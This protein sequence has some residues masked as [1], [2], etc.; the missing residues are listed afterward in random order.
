MVSNLYP[1]VVRG[2]YE[3]ECAGV[4]ERL[5]GAGH[6]VRVLTSSEERAVHPASEDVVR[7]LDFLD[8]VR[9]DSLR[10][11]V[12]A[13]RGARTMRRELASFRPE[14]VF[15]WNGSQVPHA[16][17]RI[18]ATSGVPLAFRI[19]EHWFGTLYSSDT[20]MRHLVPGERGLRGIWARLM[21]L[22]N[23]HPDLRL[24]LEGTTP[25]AL[26]WNSHALQRLNPVPPT[27]APVLEDLVYP[28]TAQAERFLAVTRAPEP[29]PTLAYV[30]RVARGKGPDVAY[31]AL[32]ALRA[33]H[34][35]PARLVLAGVIEPGVREWLDPLART[36][37]IAQHVELRGQLDT[38]GLGTVLAGAHAIVVPP[39]WQ[40][41][42]PLICVEAA[43][44]R[45]PIVAARSGG[46]PELVHDREHALLFDLGD[47]EGCADALA[48]TLADRKATAA[49]VERAFA[50]GREFSLEG[51]MTA[52]ERFVDAA[53][54]ALAPAAER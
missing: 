30:G 22:V 3:V 37:G 11:P 36:L 13:L 39:T 27:I 1:P 19:C 15:V 49:R 50:R 9:R 28:V 24:D 32:A 41:P 16:A 7:E 5:R 17:L 38:R 29:E 40:E 34:G 46:I 33:R 23:R 52:T 10:A 14:L 25:A 2:G 53:M 51:Y 21:R 35:V 42:A 12:A 4:V 8:Y 43:L 18:A 26:C 45:V 44:A 54:A 6:R 48:E 31:R 47:A 20:F